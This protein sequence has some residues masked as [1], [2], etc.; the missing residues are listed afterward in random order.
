MIGNDL[1]NWE[2]E[3]QRR[4]AR[5]STDRVVVTG[6]FTVN[7]HFLVAQNGKVYMDLP[8]WAQADGYPTA[9]VI[10]ARVD[11]PERI[12][13]LARLSAA[14]VM[15][16]NLP[17]DAVQAEDPVPGKAAWYIQAWTSGTPLEEEEREPDE[18]SVEPVEPPKPAEM[19]DFTAV[20]SL[21]RRYESSGDPASISTGTGDLGGVSYGLYQFASAVGVVD[22][23]VAWLQR[24]SDPSL[25][26]YGRVL[27]THPVNSEE[28]KDA[29][30]ELGT[31]DPGNFGRL[32]DEFVMKQYLT[33]VQ[34]LLVKEK[35]H[36]SHHT[37]AL[38][39]VAFARAIQNGP[40]GAKNLFVLAGT[41]LG[42]PNLSYLDDAY[43]DDQLIG[44]VYDQL[45]DE[46]DHVELGDDGWLRSPNDLVRGSRSVVNGQRTRFV[47]ERADALALLR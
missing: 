32:Q 17:T 8:E 3:N 13:A 6:G 16:Y 15:R 5:L 27:A 12:E 4:R 28:F 2:I 31:V 18:A 34:R 36:L 43:F 42:Y 44:A 38:R 19:D 25:A 29:W 39:A 40:T 30:R 47:S 41:R 46:C 24:Y 26:N 9:V 45:V 20:A 35:L 7:P 23:F 11:T 1:N 10:N 22:D 14:L 37:S 21:A 33:P